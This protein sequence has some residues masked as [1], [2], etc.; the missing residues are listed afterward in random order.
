VRRLL[1]GHFDY[2]D[3]GMMDRTHVRWFTRYS[4]REC[5][6][7]AGLER[8][9]VSAVPLVP[10]IDAGKP[11]GERAGRVLATALPDAFAGSLHAIGWAGLRP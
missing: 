6:E 2:A 9:A 10:R 7:Q 1:K 11:W 3:V 8:V 5:F 4:I